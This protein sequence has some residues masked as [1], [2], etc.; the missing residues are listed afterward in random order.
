MT[1]S[2]TSRPATTGLHRETFKRGSRTYYNSSVFFPPGI[3]RDVYALYG[4]VRVADDYVDRVPQD[5]VGFAGFRQRYARALGERALGRGIGDPIID[6]FTEL[7]SRRGFPPEWADA[8]LRSMELDL[9]RRIYRTREETLE[10]IYGSAEV[11]GLFMARLLGL[12]EEAYGAARMLG[13]SMQYINFIRDIDEDRRL[14]RSYLP[15]DGPADRL[16]D[17]AYA[18]GHADEFRRYLCHHL[19]LYDGWQRE[20]EA[21]FRFLP[22]R[23]RIPIETASD[24]YRWTAKVIRKDPFVVFARKVKPVRLRIFA[25]ALHNALAR[26]RAD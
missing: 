25:A 19:D 10:Y 21:G 11:I 9:S 3:R 15:W 14:G 26:P 4:F 12:P 7:S 6:A 22:R 17:P 20:A 2:D 5:A 23:A 18:A 8:F 13:R 24:M 1:A 16:A